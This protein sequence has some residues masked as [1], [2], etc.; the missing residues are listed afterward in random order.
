MTFLRLD[1]LDAKS[2]ELVAR[3]A[4]TVLPSLTPSKRLKLTG[5]RI[6][7]IKCD[8]TVPHCRRCTE[9]G[10][11]CDGPIKF[12]VSFVYDQPVSRSTTPK[13][14]LEVSVFAPSRTYDERRTFY[15]FTN[16]APIL[17][18]QVDAGFWDDL[19][20]RLAQTYDF[21]W[22]TILC[23]GNLLEHVPYME[24]R[25][26]SGPTHRPKIVNQKHSQALGFYNK[27]IANVRQ[28]FVSGQM[29]DS[30]V[31]LSY[32]LFVSVECQQRNDETACELLKKC[33]SLVHEK[34]ASPSLGQNSTTGRA[35][36]QVVTP[37]VLRRALLT[38]TLGHPLPP[39]CVAGG[40]ASLLLEATLRRHPSLEDAK[41][42]LHNLVFESFQMVRLGEMVPNVD[43]KDPAKVFFMAER[44]SL[45]DK[46]LLWK[47]SVI[48]GNIWN[49]DVVALWI[50]SYLLMYCETSYISLATCI[51]TPQ[52]VFDKYMENFV[53]IIEHATVYLSQPANVRLGFEPGVIPPLYFCATKCRDPML[54]RQA[55]RLMQ[56]APPQETFWAISEPVRVAAKVISVEEGECLP[57][58]QNHSPHSQPHSPYNGLPPEERRFTHST[59]LT[60]HV[61]GDNTPHQFLE[62]SRYE[63]TADGGRR[64]VYEYVWLDPEEELWVPNSMAEYGLV[65]RGTDMCSDVA[66]SGTLWESPCTFLDGRRTYMDNDSALVSCQV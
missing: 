46:L 47:E 59:V 31:I 36:L 24:Q 64:L 4:S 34:A 32:I 57:H 48:A 62:L 41:L 23:L 40:R 17:A 28:L 54:R 42:Q 52:I 10:R 56:Q 12:K 44:R 18:G 35:I 21:I 65:T 14:Q 60:R 22:D 13:P 53:A 61:P 55:L 26:T 7:K 63:V 51:F 6:R 30:A 29:D 39:R 1:V 5:L 9:T 58:S 25:D 38:A 45:L 11:K 37:F 19:V 43:D 27:A 15:Y 50:V 33:C 8:E 20:P 16:T 49:G 66:M 2:L 3:P